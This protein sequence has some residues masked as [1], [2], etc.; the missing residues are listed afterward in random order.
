MK[1]RTIISLSSIPPRFPHLGPTLETLL[2]QKP[3]ADEI[4]LWIPRRYRR[5]PDWD[6]GLPEVPAGVVIRRCEED[7]GP[8]TKFLPALREA[9]GQA[10]MIVIC[11]DD[12][13]FAEDWLAALVTVARERPGECVAGYGKALPRDMGLP[14]RKGRMPR[15]ENLP[16]DEINRLRALERTGRPLPLNHVVSSGYADILEGYCGALLRPGFIGPEIFSIP[17]VLWAVDDVWLS[18]HL[19]LRGVPIWVD[20]RVPRP[21]VRPE[22][23]RVDPLLRAEIDGQGREEA[24]RSCIRFYRTHHAIW[25][26]SLRERVAVAIRRIWAAA[27]AQARP[28]RSRR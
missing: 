14:L 6:G 27:T 8:A 28:W 7:H 1:E 22:A 25:R 2:A 9:A 16:G 3:G 26:P 18:G 15:V 19:E 13:M 10:V 5:F 11:D 21:P 12:R 20:E 23:H 4:Q 24:D 17:P